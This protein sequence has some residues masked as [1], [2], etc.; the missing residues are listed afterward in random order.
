MSLY[1]ADM[2]ASRLLDYRQYSFYNL[3]CQAGFDCED[4]Y[5]SFLC[6]SQ[7]TKRL[8]LLFIEFMKGLPEPIRTKVKTKYDRPEDPRDNYSKSIACADI[9]ELIMMLQE[10]S[11]AVGREIVRGRFDDEDPKMTAEKILTVIQTGVILRWAE[12][13]LPQCYTA[14]RADVLK[15][16]DDTD[17]CV[18]EYRRYGLL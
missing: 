14:I 16:P 12:K 5:T 6:G 15:A 17:R 3:V 1:L 7:P 11:A 4:E 10:S 9:S 8:E 18:D 2:E 13:H